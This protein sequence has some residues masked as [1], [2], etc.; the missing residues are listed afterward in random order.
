[1]TFSKPLRMCKSIGSWNGSCVSSQST[2]TRT[3]EERRKKRRK[4]GE[5]WKE[6]DKKKKDGCEWTKKQK[7]LHPTKVRGTKGNWGAVDLKHIY[8]LYK[9]P[10]KKMCLF[11]DKVHGYTQDQAF[12]IFQSSL[13]L[14]LVLLC[15]LVMT[16]YHLVTHHHHHHHHQGDI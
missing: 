13:L 14:L 1:M 4:R 5:C 12:G 16:N 6:E 10:C 2:L 8:T 9:P 11:T 15:L 7:Q 3:Q